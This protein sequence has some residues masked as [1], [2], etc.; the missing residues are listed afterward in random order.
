MLVIA[1]VLLCVI[2]FLGYAN[3]QNFSSYGILFAVKALEWTPVDS[4]NLLSVF[5]ASTLV[6]RCVSI[7]S[8]KYVKVSTLL[9]AST[10]TGLVGTILMASMT[11][12]TPYALWI[13]ASLL[14]LGNGN[15]LANALNAGK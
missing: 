7:V 5:W 9:F 4:S 3:E 10:L 11:N 8:A 15:V 12:V 1:A 13:G 2:S 14:G 6:C